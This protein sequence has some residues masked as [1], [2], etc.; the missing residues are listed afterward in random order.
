MLARGQWNG[1]RVLSESWIDAL[2]TPCSLNP[3]YGL[4][5][6]LQHDASGRQVCFAAQGGG[7]HQCI[8]VPDH[9]LVVVVRWIRDDAWPAFLDRA[10]TLTDDRPPHGPIRYLFERVNAAHSS[11]PRPDEEPPCT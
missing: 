3:M 11:S 8:V 6:W 10:L 4:M 7:A 1:V 2:R 9:D 5:W